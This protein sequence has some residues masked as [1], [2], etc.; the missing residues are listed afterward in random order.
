MELSGSLTTR[1]MFDA[2]ASALSDP[3]FEKGYDVLSYHLELEQ[4]L[5]STEA[6]DLAL[7]LAKFAG[8]LAHAKWGVVTRHPASYG[9]MR[10]LAVH[11]LEVP[12]TLRVFA[13]EEEA[14]AWLRP[15]AE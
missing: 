13:T 1:E 15:Q 2:I 5:T 10:M 14:L 7:Y 8:V 4:F 12:M 11:L 6:F 3:A 9:M